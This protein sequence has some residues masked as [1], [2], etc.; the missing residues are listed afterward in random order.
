LT[1]AAIDPRPVA[2]AGRVVR[3]EPMRAEHAEALI[4]VGLG[5]AL[6][7]WFPFALDTADDMRGFVRAVLAS[8]EVGASVPF[9]T[10]LQ[11]T[12]EVVGS[13]SFLAID[14]ANRRLEIGA[15]WIGVAWQRT[16]CNGEAKYLQLRHCF[17][18][19]GCQRVEF[20][21][22]SLNAR[23]REALLRIGATEEGTFRNHMV[24]PDGRLRHSVYFSVI[25]SEWPDV[26]RRLEARLEQQAR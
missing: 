3:L 1:R 21:T 24:C 16:A 22:D 17:E 26:K 25:D 19:L 7:R 15:T 20:K 5:P 10:S 11:A 2:L 12:G 6:F 23:S 9:V 13:T 18:E 8:A 4:A 14:R